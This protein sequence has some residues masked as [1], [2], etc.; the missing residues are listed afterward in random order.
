[1]ITKNKKLNREE[2]SHYEFCHKTV[3]TGASVCVAC[4]P[5]KYSNPTG[6]DAV[7]LPAAL[8]I[9]QWMSDE[10]QGFNQYFKITI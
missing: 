10:F 1:L 7:D 3:F 9:R 5:G 4:A 2:Y 8:S 6:A